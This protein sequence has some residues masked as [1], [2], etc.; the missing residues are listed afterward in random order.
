MEMFTT[1]G[2]FKKLIDSGTDV[3]TEAIVI[4]MTTIDI[5]AALQNCGDIELVDICI[6]CIL[7]CTHRLLALMCMTWYITKGF[8]RFSSRYS[9][10]Y[11]MARDP[12]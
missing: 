4:G 5:R 3:G 2:R 8:F 7:I 1:R 11:D 9:L 12:N 10:V 6:V